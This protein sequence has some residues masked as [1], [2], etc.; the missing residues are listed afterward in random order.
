MNDI[1]NFKGLHRSRCSLNANIFSKKAHLGVALVIQ[2][3]ASRNSQ[4]SRQPLSSFSVLLK[5]TSKYKENKR[6]NEENGISRGD[7]FLS[8]H[9]IKGGE[10]NACNAGSVVGHIWEQ[11]GH[12][13]L[14]LSISKKHLIHLF[15]I[16]KHAFL[17]LVEISYKSC[18]PDF[19]SKFLEGNRS[20]TL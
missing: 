1:A 6:K 18:L 20:E 2:W 19:W 17:H 16:S 12:H 15:N 10:D 11:A 9:L 7:Y 14:N 13:C 8:G 4:K 5:Q 3:V